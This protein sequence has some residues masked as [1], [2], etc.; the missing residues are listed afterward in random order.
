MKPQGST[1]PRS[2]K[3]N[4]QAK[5]ET[6]RS[7]DCPWVKAGYFLGQPS[8]TYSFGSG[9]RTLFSGDLT[10]NSYSLEPI[11]GVLTLPAMCFSHNNLA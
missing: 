4:E 3:K 6:I 8:R 7:Y 10:M 11:T 1:W 5:I 9:D 2:Q